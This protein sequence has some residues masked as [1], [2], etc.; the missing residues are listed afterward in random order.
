MASEWGDARRGKLAE[1]VVGFGRALR[2]AGV[3]VDSERVANAQRALMLAGLQSKPDV[4]AALEAVLISR[5]QD[6]AVFAELFDAYFRNPE[7]ANKLLA[8]ML[9]NA[10]GK[11]ETPS[12]RPRVAQALSP[13][14]AQVTNPANSERPEQ[15]VEFDAA[16]T[17]STRE[18]LQ[19]ADFNALSADE[20]HVVER[21]ARE[22]SLPVPTVPSRR[23]R[24]ARMGRGLHW[25]KV[26][27]GLI[28]HDGEVLQWWRHRR[29]PE[30]LPLVVL[31]DVS[32]SMERYAR[33]LLSF[34]HAATQRR[35]NRTRQLK[36]RDVFAFGTRLTDLTPAF[37]RRDTDAMLAEV[38]RVVPDFAGGT[39]L[40]DA[41]AT[42]RSQH[43]RRLVGRRSVV[44]LV[45]DGLDTGS[46]EA[47][48]TELRWLKR[49]SRRL[50]WLNPLLRYDAYQPLA[51]GA[52]VLHRHAH[53]MLAVHNLQHL[54]SLA[55]S[56]ATLLQQT[57]RPAQHL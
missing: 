25:P 7:V 3:A 28:R 18:R 37:A 46:S 35:A 15:S 48:D 14:V 50:L 43:A 31:L 23:H 49:H 39:R 38:G 32:G 8:Q 54:R 33:M 40:G 1:N 17:A 11:A 5:Q 36:R 16:M 29:E 4:A 41:L 52:Q 13:A 51:G 47:L 19:Q 44:L 2:R 10:E 56:I 6:R 22:V 12:K 24:A 34:L 30:S 21:L 57:Q 20:Y 53:A 45:S 26:L 42:L 9:P 55:A 27:Q